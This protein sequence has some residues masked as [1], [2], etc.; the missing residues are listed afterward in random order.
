MNLAPL[1]LLLASAAAKPYTRW[2]PEDA[3]PQAQVLDPLSWNVLDPIAPQDKFDGGSVSTPA[4]ASLLPSRPQHGS[5]S[6]QLFYPPGHDAESLKARPFHIYD[7]KF[8]AIIGDSPTLTLIASSPVDPL[9]HEAVV[10]HPPTDDVFF[11]Q[12]AGAKDAGTGLAK[13]AVV[14]KISLAQAD[15]VTHKANASGEVD[16]VVLGETPQVINPNG[17]ANFRGQVLFAGE[18]MGVD[19]P[20]ALYVMNPTPP[21]NTT[22]ILNNF[23]GRQFNSLNDVAIHPGNKWIYFTDV[24]YGVLQDFR[25]KNNIRRQVYRFNPDTGVVEAIADQMLRPNGLTFS[26]DGKWLYV[27]DT[28]AAHG[29]QGTDWEDPASM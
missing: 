1:F 15:R 23:F 19:I 3:P 13:S 27:A 2:R 18:G 25:G 21:Y 9:F 20:S 17:G 14:Q 7:P 11:V 24:D 16:V 6:P 22:V 4:P 28:G 10:W 26:P 29:F 12:N 8:Y 5:R